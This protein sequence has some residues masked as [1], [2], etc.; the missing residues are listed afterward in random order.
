MNNELYDN[1]FAVGKKLKKDRS[2]LENSIRN[3]THGSKNIPN[4]KNKVIELCI[5]AQEPI[6]KIISTLSEDNYN[7]FY[8]FIIGLNNGSLPNK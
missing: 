5:I 8:D 3:M 6:P 1:G 2:V 4:I 7:E